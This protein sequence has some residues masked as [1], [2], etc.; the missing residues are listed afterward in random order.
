VISVFYNG[1]FTRQP[2]LKTRVVL[3][4]LFDGSRF[5]EV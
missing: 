5:F 2:K 3:E 1:I 4:V